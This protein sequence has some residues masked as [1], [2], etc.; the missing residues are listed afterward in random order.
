MPVGAVVVNVPPH[1]LLVPLATVK[2]VGSVSLKATPVSAVVFA[3]GLAR[4][5]VRLV[6]PFTATLLGLNC[7]AMVGGA[8]TKML[9]VLLATPVPPSV[10]VGAPAV[11][12]EV[13]AVTPVTVTDTRHVPL[14][15]AMVAPESEIVPGLVVVRVP[16]QIELVP[17]ATVRLLGSES[18]N[19][20]PLKLCVVF[21]FVRVKLTLV[22]PFKGTLDAPNALAMVGGATTVSAAVLLVVP[23]PPSTDVIAPVTLF[24]TPAVV[25]CTVTDIV[26]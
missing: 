22:V 15:A 8:T 1:V 6:V 3:L 2:P 17:L 5:N 11:L 4:V 24:F 26:H 10:D 16:P 9:A 18:V 14:L 19:P 12:V 13:P 7:L 20:T 21:G 23:V 25:P